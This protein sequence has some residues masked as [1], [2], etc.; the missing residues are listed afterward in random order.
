MRKSDKID[1]NLCHSHEHLGFKAPARSTVRPR[2][3]CFHYNVHIWAL[4]LK[5]TNYIEFLDHLHSLLFKH[6]THKFCFTE[7]HV[8][9]DLTF[10]CDGDNSMNKE[11]VTGLL[12]TNYTRTQDDGLK[13]R[14]SSSTDRALCGEALFLLAG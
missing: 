9:N 14:F 2:L 8:N 13:Q 4:N 3:Q 7:R 1:T 11:P 12:R 5:N 6:T 10:S